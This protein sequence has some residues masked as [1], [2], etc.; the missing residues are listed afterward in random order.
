MVRQNYLRSSNYCW[1]LLDSNRF[2][3]LI[4][5]F[6]VNHTSNHTQNFCL[7]LFYSRYSSWRLSVILEE[8]LRL[9]A[10]TVLV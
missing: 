6:S 7:G 4:K 8:A 9:L 5:R 10:S 3:T 1:L 2:F